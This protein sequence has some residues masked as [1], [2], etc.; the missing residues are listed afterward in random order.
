[1][2]VELNYILRLGFSIG[3]FS[4]ASY[5]DLKKREVS[6]K[7]WIIA[8]I[9]NFPLTLLGEKPSTIAI[10]F[11]TCFV[12]GLLLY[13]GFKFGGAD[14]K[15]IWILSVSLPSN[16][17]N[18]SLLEKPLIFPL[19]VAFNAVIISTLYIIVNVSKN[20]FFYLKNKKLFE[21][22]YSLKEKILLF[23]FTQKITMEEFIKNRHYVSVVRNGRINFKFDAR[24]IDF[25]KIDQR[26]G[27]ELWC[28]KVQPFLIYLTISI[29]LTIFLGDLALYFASLFLSIV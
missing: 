29:P 7:I 21:K 16:P 2:S 11:I 1:M 12:F 24:E 13:Y 10:S 4:I 27:D 8:L 23:F 26:V 19:S 25:D 3:I 17:L 14:S 9:L 22:E 20:I 28:E 5:F 6:D 15:A 18:Y